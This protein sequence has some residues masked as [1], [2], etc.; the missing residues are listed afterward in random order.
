MFCEI[1]STLPNHYVECRAMG[2]VKCGVSSPENA[3]QKLVHDGVELSC[4][5]AAVDKAGN[6]VAIEVG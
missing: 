3:L 5:R 1:T 4:P 6:V 2:D